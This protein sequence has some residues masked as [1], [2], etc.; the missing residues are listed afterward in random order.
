MSHHTTHTFGCGHPR[1]PENTYKRHPV[2]YRKKDGSLSVH[3]GD[4]CAT[5][6]KERVRARDRR[7]A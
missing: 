2:Y 1:T 6:Q 5:C 4:F 7:A 3:V